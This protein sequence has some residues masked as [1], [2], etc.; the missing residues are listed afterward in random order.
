MGTDL[1]VKMIMAAIVL[2]S[3]APK[4]AKFILSFMSAIMPHPYRGGIGNSGGED[5]V[6][7]WR[8]L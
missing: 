8:R 3:F 7:F 2:N 1:T 6:Q 5:Q 4:A